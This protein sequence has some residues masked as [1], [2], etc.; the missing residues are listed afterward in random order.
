MFSSYQEDADDTDNLFNYTRNRNEIDEVVPLTP[1]FPVSPEILY[2]EHNVYVIP[3]K[4]FF[5]VFF[6]SPMDTLNKHRAINVHG[7]E[8]LAISAIAEARFR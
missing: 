7:R 4:N 2:G 1:A 5:A 3:L 6:R 8:D